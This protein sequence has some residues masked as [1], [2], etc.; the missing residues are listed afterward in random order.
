MKIIPR[1][2]FSILLLKR[3][4]KISNATDSENDCDYMDNNFAYEKI[5]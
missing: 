4:G 5:N 3:N 1:A 2:E